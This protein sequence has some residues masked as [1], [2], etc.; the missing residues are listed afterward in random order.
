MTYRRLDDPE[1]LDALLRTGLGAS[2]DPAFDRFTQIVRTVLRV[3]V[4][5]VS[6]VDDERQVFPGAFGLGEP[7]FG[8]R[9][10]PLS[11]S[12]CQH[13]VTTAAPLVISDA[14]TDPRVAGNLAITDLSVVGYAGMPLTDADGFVLGSLCAIDTAPREWTEAEL[15]L[16]ADLAAACSDSLR[17]RI[18]TRL[19]HRGE[20]SARARERVADANLDRS[21][22]LL[23]ASVALARTVTVADVSAAV[24]ELVTGTLDPDYVGVS[25]VEAG[26]ISLRSGADLPAPVAARWERY[27]GT[28]R[29]P[30]AL[31]VATGAPVLLRDLA[32]VAERAPDALATFREMGWQ[33]AA[34]VPLPGPHGPIGALTFAWKE[35][36]TLD[37]VE[38]AVLAALAGYVGQAIRRADYLYSREQ[39]AELLQQSMLT[40]LPEAAPFELAARYEPAARGEYVGGD[41]YDAVAV[42]PGELA[43]VVGDVTGHD[44]RAAAHMGQLRS[45]LR[46]YVVDRHE[47]P[48][49]L[50]RRLDNAMHELGDRTPTTAVLAYVRSEEGGGHRLQWANAGHPAPLLLEADG[51]V[52]TLTGRD[53]LLGYHR[54]TPRTNHTSVLSP[55]STVLMFTDGLIETRHDDLD[56]RKLQLRRVLSGLAGVPLPDLLDEVYR[57]LAGDDHEDDVALL[58]LR[59][60]GP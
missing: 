35:P 20:D 13:V 7:W 31:A 47:P 25:L 60:P 28:A 59:T 43:L 46:A 48:S 58:A 42:D 50:L 18:A 55:G 4:A 57:R 53:T 56:E 23:R 41:W 9:Q 29:T 8:R 54:H 21:Q 24:R 12:F 52:T 2:P 3:P 6:L 10:T 40:D 11:H 22:V 36:F 49:A 51:T 1:R 44:M 33:S 5:L 39:V 45:M 30:S 17:L 32:A 14:R 15:A 26:H 37:D 27:R 34:S 38:R 16:L 19:A